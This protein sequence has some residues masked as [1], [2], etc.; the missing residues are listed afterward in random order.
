MKKKIHIP[1]EVA[2]LK[3]KNFFPQIF[4]PLHCQPVVVNPRL[5]KLFAASRSS[6]RCFGGF[7]FL[8]SSFRHIMVKP[9]SSS[10]ASS[11]SADQKVP[12]NLLKPPPSPG[13][14][15]WFSCASLGAEVAVSTKPKQSTNGGLLGSFTAET[16]VIDRRAVTLGVKRLSCTST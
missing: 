13:A 14:T 1:Q 5:W 10:K 2:S 9:F 6:K 4:P 7:F 3:K 12:F 16:R 15:R 8:P 11:M